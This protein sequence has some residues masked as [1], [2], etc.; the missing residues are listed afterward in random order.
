MQASLAITTLDRACWIS[1]EPLPDNA[2]KHFK[3]D[4][5]QGYGLW[6]LKAHA[7]RWKTGGWN[8]KQ[9]SEVT[10][11]RVLWHLG[12]FCGPFQQTLDIDGEGKTIV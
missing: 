7:R 3:N 5:V 12:S 8:W 1:I 6:R 4:Q 11:F 9:L 2:F 10:I